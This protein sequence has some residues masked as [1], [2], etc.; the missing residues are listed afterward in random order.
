[1]LPRIKRWKLEA[2]DRLRYHPLLRGAA[3]RCLT[4][5]AGGNGHGQ[6]ELV[7]S[8]VK[9]CTAARCTTVQAKVRA[10]QRTIQERV[11][12]LRP[13]EV[14]WSGLVRNIEQPRIHRALIL[15]PW[16]GPR[17]KGV[18]Y[19]SFEVDWFRLLWHCDLQAFS[20]R[21]DLVV[22]PTD[23][24]H[25]VLNYVFAGHYPGRIYSLIS[26]H[27][28]IVDLPRV[29]PNYVVVPLYASQWVLP[30]YFQPLPLAKRDIDLIMVANFAKVKRHLA[31]F[32]ALKKMPA[33]FR[34]HLIG[35][36]QDGRT[37][38]TLRAEAGYYGVADR[39]TI[40]S[41]VPDYRDVAAAMCRAR[42]SVILSRREGSCVVVA[43]SMF[44]NTPIGLL[45]D[46]EIG[47]RAFINPQTGRLLKHRDL[48]G[49]LTELIERAGEFAPR[50]WAEKNIDC[51]SSSHTLNEL[52]KRHAA[53][54]GQEWT[55]DIAPLCWRPD[56]KLVR[57]ADVARLQ[58]EREDMK[59]RFG[60]EVGPF[61]A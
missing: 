30:E 3:G 4:W 52:L 55:R 17:E 47:S 60:V 6:Q 12:E 13:K 2:V 61:P 19:V 22:S 46:A 24:P 10:I 49:Q 14:D 31:L 51:F 34:V 54:D 59:Q 37:A 18:M 33:R 5:T 44:A 7:R 42:A 40:Q 39:F 36:D 48:A 9:L 57:A 45:E 15:K 21:Y 50:A 41:N 11:R 16:M 1:M 8:I 25:S 38:E 56:P 43:E 20:E 26:H 58:G 23:S 35:Q 32:A 29:A 27:C 28:D 53:A